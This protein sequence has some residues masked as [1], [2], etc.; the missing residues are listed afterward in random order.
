MRA[1]EPWDVAL[2]VVVTAMVATMAGLREPRRKALV[3]AIPVPFTLA[4]LAVGNR[5]QSTHVAA[6]SLLFA[7]TF[8]VYLLHRRA[9]VPLALAIVTMALCFLAGAIWLN[10]VLPRGELGFWSAVGLTLVLGTVLLRTLPMRPEAGAAHD[11][12]LALK[13]PLSLAT[14]VGLVLLKHA[15]GGFMTL[16]PMV[17]VLASYENR[18]GLWANTRQIPVVMLTMLPLMVTSHVA[19][20]FVGLPASLALGWLPF[21][22]ALA[23]FLARGWRGGLAAPGA[24]KETQ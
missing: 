3:L 5:L 4:S 19:S 8:G 10:A 20:P 15:I 16:F 2:V 14:V 1:L 6:L 9:R 24:A 17:G 13:L 12:S 21:S 18:H 11:V 22:I 23:P 7:Y